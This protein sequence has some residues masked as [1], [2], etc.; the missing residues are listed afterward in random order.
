[1]RRRHV[2][3]AAIAAGSVLALA[4]CSSTPA[5]TTA[6]SPAG[7]TPS[8]TTPAAET[9]AGSAEAE[10]TTEAADD[11]AG[12]TAEKPEKTGNPVLDGERQIVIAPTDTYETV[13][14]VDDK[15]H[16]A[17]TDGDSDTTLF[18]LVPVNDEKHWIRTAKADSSGEQACIGLSMQS[19]GPAMLDAAPCDASASGQLFTIQSKGEVEGK[20]RYAI[21]GDKGYNVRALDDEGVQAV[22]GASGKGT[23]FGFADN[24]KAPAGPGAE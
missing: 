13:L 12:A 15:G 1:M 20:F 21:K 14:H 19:S 24:G 3:A 2:A 11:G 8:A 6:A 9:G 18:V 17:L 23:T 22:A 10:P 16:L 7:S 4:A 5:D